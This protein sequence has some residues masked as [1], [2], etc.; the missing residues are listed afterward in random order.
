MHKYVYVFLLI[1]YVY[2]F[3]IVCYNLFKMERM[4]TPN[5]ESFEDI[6]MAY[7]NEDT[8]EASKRYKEKNIKRVP[9]D[10]QISDYNLLKAAADAC[11]EKVN[12]YIKKAIRQRMER[13]GVGLVTEDST[14]GVVLVSEDG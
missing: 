4:Y 3:W 12:E 8:Y 9:L 10:M 7:Y 13:E 5:N 11:G 14:G 1:L 2:T 6:A